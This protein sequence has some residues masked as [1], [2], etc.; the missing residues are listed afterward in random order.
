[1]ANSMNLWQGVCIEEKCK[2]GLTNSSQFMKVV[3]LSIH[4]SHIWVAL[5]MEKY[6]IH[7]KRIIL[8]CPFK[9][10]DKSLDEAC[11][12]P[13]FHCQAENGKF[14][15]KRVHVDGYYAQVQGQ[16]LLTGLKWCD[17]VVH[18]NVSRCI[19]VERI[20]LDHDYCEQTLLPKLKEFYFDHAIK[21]LI[22]N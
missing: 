17:F 3:L 1:M 10:R 21:Y 2:K 18:L 11:Q 8:D 9:W 16:L 4:F 5:L 7:L 22:E 19:N 14:Y 15:L 13:T 20:Y 6:L 12:D